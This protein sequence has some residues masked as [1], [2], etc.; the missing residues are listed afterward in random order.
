MFWCH[1]ILHYMG[2]KV[3]H[4][5][6][7][8]QLP[9]LSLDPLSTHTSLPL[10]WDLDTRPCPRAGIP[11]FHSP[12]GQRKEQAASSGVNFIQWEMD[13][14]SDWGREIPPAFFLLL[15]Y[16]KMQFLYWLFTQTVDE[17]ACHS[18]LSLWLTLELHPEWWVHSWH[19]IVSFSASFPFF[20]FSRLRACTSPTKW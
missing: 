6:R 11:A 13:D 8:L 14:G 4:F 3:R 20:S 12:R 16:F 1:Q 17:W 18:F 9:P 10:F 15:G 7:A 5:L 2:H 19:C